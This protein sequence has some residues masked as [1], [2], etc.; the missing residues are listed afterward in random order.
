MPTRRDLVLTNTQTGVFVLKRGDFI[1]DYVVRNGCWDSHL[2]SLIEEL[3][4]KGGGTAVD[5]GAHLGFL[6]AAM[7]KRFARVLSFEPNDFNYRLLVANMAINAFSHV[8]CYNVPLFSSAVSLSLGKPEQQEIPLPIGSDGDFDGF[9]GANLGAYL[10]T[11]EGTGIFY[12]TARTLDSYDLENVSFIKINA[13]GADGE[14]IRGALETIR[15]CK[16][17]VVFEWEKHLSQ[18]FTTSLDDVTQL[19]QAAGYRIDVLSRSIE[20]QCDYIARPPTVPVG[21]RA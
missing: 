6:S 13:Q 21:A 10:F 17:V 1:S 20:K 2:L 16:P 19:L 15:R 8:Q 18:R 7:A 9:A 3:G 5:V 11:Q 12:R 14:V 4:D